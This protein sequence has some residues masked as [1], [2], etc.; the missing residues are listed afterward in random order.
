MRILVAPNA[1][2]ESLS[3]AEAARCLARGLRRG[4]PEATIETL[5]IADGGDGTARVLAEGRLRRV[6]VGGPLGDAVEARYGTRDGGETAVIEM[7]EASGLRLVEPTRRDPT[8]SD[9]RGTGELMRHAMERGARRIVVGIG[10]SATVD[11]GAGMAAALGYRFLDAQGRELN[12]NP[13]QLRRAARIDAQ[14]WRELAQRLGF[15][16]EI[17]VASDVRNR[18]LGRQGAPRVFGPQKGATPQ[19]VEELEQT[20]GHLADLI[21]RDLGAR[22]RGLPGGG[23]A[24]GLGAGLVAFCG[25]RIEP[26]ADLV[27]RELG[28]EERARGADWVI[29][30]EG[31]LDGQTRLGK[32]PA[33]AARMARAAGARVIAVAGSIDAHSWRALRCDYD[34]AISICDGPMALDEAIG[35]APELLRRTGET[36]GALISGRC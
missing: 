24:G 15:E 6:R 29:T 20:L 3:A 12:P 25:A 19:Q 11:G 34:A 21:E 32:A 23:A 22:V 16:P 10:G 4:A 14:G 31:R 9:T 27:L 33:C 28:F 7:A 30:G 2:K 5:P 26:G 18:L 13:G 8:V 35:R 36:I 1:F 17:L